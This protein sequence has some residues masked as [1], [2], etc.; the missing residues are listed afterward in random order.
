MNYIFYNYYYIEPMIFSRTNKTILLAE[1]EP[2]ARAVYRKHLAGPDVTVRICDDLS[3]LLEHL[4]LL[5]PDLLIINPG[6]NPAR[7]LAFLQSIKNTQPAL[8]IITLGYGTPDDYLDRFM[9]I[10][11][12]YH[13]NRHL[14]RPQDVA[15]AA[16]QVLADIYSLNT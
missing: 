15:I 1:P 5:E 3:K 2:E 6:K 8:R 4:A 7:S 10:G 14:T 16:Q 12:S 9:Q 11:V 13:I